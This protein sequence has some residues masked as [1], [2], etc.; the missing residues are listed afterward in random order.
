MRSMMSCI[1]GPWVEKSSPGPPRVTLPTKVVM[2]SMYVTPIT[3]SFTMQLALMV[4]TVGSDSTAIPSKYGLETPSGSWSLCKHAVTPAKPGGHIA[5]WT[6]PNSLVGEGGPDW[7]VAHLVPQFEGF[8]PALPPNP[9]YKAFI[10][11]LLTKGES[12]QQ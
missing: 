4:T 10:L 9:G 1:V 2:V 5:L 11:G 6:T 12:L 7:V 3:S 8:E